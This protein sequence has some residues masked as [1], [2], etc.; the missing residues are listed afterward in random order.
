M[1]NTAVCK[2]SCAQ[3]L[4]GAFI[5]L[6]Q[7]EESTTAPMAC[8]F[9]APWALLPGALLWRHHA[10]CGCSKHQHVLSPHIKCTVY[11]LCGGRLQNGL[12]CILTVSGLTLRFKNALNRTEGQVTM[13]YLLEGKKGIFP[14]LGLFTQGQSPVPPSE[15]AKTAD[16]FMAINITSIDLPPLEKY[17]AEYVEGR[18]MVLWNLELDTLRS[19][20]GGSVHACA[21]QK[22]CLHDI[23]AMCMVDGVHK[24]TEYGESRVHDQHALRQ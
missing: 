22:H 19:D 5:S 1:A 18:P 7:T 4:N 6:Y 2:C 13:G 16:V 21:V 14:S 24:G 12:H 23:V 11:H 8:E 3:S 17:I 15:S 20:L 9:P 10:C